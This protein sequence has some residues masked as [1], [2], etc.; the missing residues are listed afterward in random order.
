M[1]LQNAVLKKYQ[2]LYPDQTLREISKKTGIQ[3]TRVFRILNG[4]EMRISEYEKF[5][6]II[7]ANS[8]ECD[9]DSFFEIYEDLKKLSTTQF[10]QVENEIKYF[11]SLNKINSFIQPYRWS[12][13]NA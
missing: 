5:R 12:V 3:Q 1:Q 8:S 13:A 6:N 4:H 9:P 11:L 7:V 10:N 2:E